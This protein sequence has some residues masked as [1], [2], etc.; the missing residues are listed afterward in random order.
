MGRWLRYSGEGSS[1]VFADNDQPSWKIHHQLSFLELKSPH[2][3]LLLIT[4]FFSY[5]FID[6]SSASSVLYFLS[7]S[8]DLSWGSKEIMASLM[9]RIFSKLLDFF[10]FMKTSSE[11]SVVETLLSVVEYL[12]TLVEY[13]NTPKPTFKV[14]LSSFTLLLGCFLWVVLV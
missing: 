7:F 2:V 10:L 5:F 9:S 4:L 1:D 8:E 6:L 13:F 14:F 3:Y 11:G 12:V